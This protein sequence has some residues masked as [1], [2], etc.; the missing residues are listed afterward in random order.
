MAF[1]TPTQDRQDDSHVHALATRFP[2]AVFV[3]DF[4]P[5]WPAVLQSVLKHHGWRGHY[6][7]GQFGDVIQFVEDERGEIRL[8]AD[9][10]APS[11]PLLLV[12]GSPDDPPSSPALQVPSSFQ[13]QRD[14]QTEEPNEPVP[15]NKADPQTAVGGQQQNHEPAPS[16]QEPAQASHPVQDIEATGEGAVVQPVTEP[17]VPVQSASSDVAAPA[18]TSK[19]SKPQRPQRRK[20]ACMKMVRIGRLLVALRACLHVVLPP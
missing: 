18:A 11:F 10:T 4:S 8:S 20:Q 16:A 3:L 12:K 7:L 6:L 19:S 1:A 2:N 15:V 14:T 9:P 17:Q 13:Q 5:H